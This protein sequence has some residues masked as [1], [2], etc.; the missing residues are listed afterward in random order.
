[1]QGFSLFHSTLCFALKLAFKMEAVSQFLRLAMFLSVFG[2][3]F[4]VFGDDISQDNE[5]N[6]FSG[7]RSFISF[8]FS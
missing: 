7:K 1:M 5:D 6:R 8:S 2:E 4:A 3:T